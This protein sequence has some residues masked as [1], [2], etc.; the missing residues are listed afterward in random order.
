[1]LVILR[2]KSN[3][4]YYIKIFKTVIYID[5]VW[6]VCMFKCMKEHKMLIFLCCTKEGYGHTKK[7]YI[8]YGKNVC[9]EERSIKYT[10]IFLY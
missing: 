7:K 10:E 3:M 9:K 2:K 1:M 8:K 6:N 4:T 5:I